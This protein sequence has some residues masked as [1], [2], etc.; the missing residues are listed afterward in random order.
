MSSRAG[1][2]QGFDSFYIDWANGRLIKQLKDMFAGKF[3][4]AIFSDPV[5][6][7]NY[8]FELSVGKIYRLPFPFSYTGGLRNFLKI[9]R[10]L[11]RIEKENDI[12]I[13]QLP[14][15]GVLS[16]LFLR[17][18]AV[19]HLCAN[20]LTAARN[21]FKYHGL[22]LVLSKVFAAM[23]HYCYIS[24]MRNRKSKLIVN[25]LELAGIYKE[26]S[27]IV[28]VSSSVSLDEM[29]EGSQINRRYDVDELN[30]LFI[31]RPSREKGFP[32]LIDA[33][34]KLVD[35]GRS[36]RLS[37]VG[38]A[39]QELQQL[40]QRNLADD[41]L[42][43]ISLHGFIPWGDTFKGIVRA[44]HCLIVASVSE[45]TPRVLIEARSQGCPVIATRVGGIVT[46]VTHGVDGLLVAPADSEQLIAAVESL[47]DESSR[48]RLATLG[49]ETAKKHS[50][51]KFSGD[52]EIAVRALTF[53]NE[54]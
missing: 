51:E 12:L 48:F 29:V 42:K 16:L 45:G 54:R 36:V 53:T 27:P 44:S 17:K 40:I 39:K 10:L 31:G 21:P 41:Y 15:A 33:F 24:L 8:D 19:F 32:T 13:I 14:F 2:V 43:R 37:I 49:L 4:V 1:H 22:S 46:S 47:F 6:Q 25:G 5:K 30:L 9:Y 3:S 20:V 18:P 28:T 35:K 26:F 11:K 7:K 52:F 23:M 34:C 38:V 50:L